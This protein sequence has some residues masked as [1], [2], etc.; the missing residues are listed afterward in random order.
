MQA[1]GFPNPNMHRGPSP[2][3]GHHAPQQTQQSAPG[4]TQMI[5]STGSF[6]GMQFSIQHRDN[7]T[8]LCA[9]LQQGYQ[10]KVIS[11]LIY[12]CWPRYWLE[13]SIKALPGTMVAM[14]SS[15]QIQGKVSEAWIERLFF[16]SQVLI[17]F[18]LNS[19]K[20]GFCLKPKEIMLS[21]SPHK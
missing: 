2:G 7:N 18:S 5:N 21:T 8:I 20:A 1:P 13:L 12:T 9:M 4:A 15:V 16:R 17:Y 11:L 10:I 3:A 6:E 14:D 19:G